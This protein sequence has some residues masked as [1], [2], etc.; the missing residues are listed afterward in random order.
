MERLRLVCSQLSATICRW[1]RQLQVASRGCE[2]M[3]VE[4]LQVYGCTWRFRGFR[5]LVVAVWQNLQV[6]AAA[7]G[8][9]QRLRMEVWL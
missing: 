5:G 9:R 4:V 6:E 1:R 2:Q 3:E 7:A 8:C